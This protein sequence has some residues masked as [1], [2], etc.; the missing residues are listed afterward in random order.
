MRRA[1]WY[2]AL[3]VLLAG[4]G[5]AGG[6]GSSSMPGTAPATGSGSGT[7]TV[8]IGQ[9]T[10]NR[11]AFDTSSVTVMLNG[12]SGFTA[13][14][15]VGLQG[16]GATA[17]FSNLPLGSYTITAQAFNAS[18]VELSEGNTTLTVVAG[19]NTA[20]LTTNFVP[21][22]VLACNSDAQTI[23]TLQLDPQSGA[24][25]N[26]S[27]STSAPGA[28][29]MALDPSEHFLY[30]MDDPRQ[31]QQ[32]TS[33][34]SGMNVFSVDGA[35]GN[36]TSQPDL[37]VFLPG[38]GEFPIVSPDDRFLYI[39]LG[40]INL[41]IPGSFIA[42][43]ARDPQTGALVPISGSPFLAG[44][45]D[46]PEDELGFI[47]DLTLDPIGH[48]LYTGLSVGTQNVAAPFSVDQTTGALSALPITTLG[49]G[50]PLG[51]SV[52]PV[53]G[54][55]L[56]TDE[57][58]IQ[59]NNLLSNG[60]LGSSST[61]TT[62]HGQSNEQTFDP[63]GHYLIE[64]DLAN[65][66]LDVYSVTNGIP[67]Y[68]SSVPTSVN[69]GVARFDNTGQVL[70]LACRG[71]SPG[72][73][74]AVQSFLWNASNGNLTLVSTVTT[75]TDSRTD[76]VAI[77]A[78]AAAA[79]GTPLPSP[80]P[81]PTVPP[82]SAPGTL[83]PLQRVVTAGSPA[84][85]VTTPDGKYLYVAGATILGYAVNADG[86]V[87]AWAPPVAKVDVPIPT[88]TG[89]L[90]VGAAMDPQG[91]YLLVAWDGL[92]SQP[93]LLAYAIGSDGSL[94]P[95]NGSPASLAGSPVNVAIDNTGTVIAVSNRSSG[96][97]STFSLNR[98]SSTL[99]ATGSVPS[100]A[101]TYG[102]AFTPDNT[103]L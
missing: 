40:T 34:V 22:F 80:T 49:L 28:F 69:P 8:Q 41:I 2:G 96:Q 10:L 23:S 64:T 6:G 100:G 72:F 16:S 87:N 99:T 48:T 44:L 57:N 81:V 29:T 95:V 9:P 67:S 7:V 4:C 94:T 73:N 31:N 76:D 59:T 42:G 52:D 43:F 74:G 93:E 55:V 98:A 63:T 38:S 65:N 71:A 90:A 61:L 17:S 21:E 18:K 70:L 20:N 46:F 12:P 5:M 62:L 45:G 86:T 82:G 103:H 15:S 77:V 26:P 54:F 53:G 101:G 79:S 11:L 32:F 35:T 60:A 88:G 1:L 78:P 25:Q 47:S 102:V 91:K 13:S 68:L 58:T 56:Y 85:M 39:Q 3:G 97:L 33:L 84:G 30:V 36:L 37:S 75:G 51:A 19:T 92:G 89:L 83:T 27:Q 50:S 66:T 24:L 14:Q